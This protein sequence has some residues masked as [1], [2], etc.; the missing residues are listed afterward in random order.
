MRKLRRKK[1][2]GSDELPPNLLKDVVNEISKP[3][4]FII[5]KSLSSGLVPDL[6][7]ISKVTPL[8]K[9][10]SDF[11]NYRPISVLPCLSKVLEQVVHRQ[12]SNY[13]EKH[14][15]LKSSQFGFRPR[16][17][18]ELACNLLVDDIRKNI[19][20]G[21]LMGVKYLDLNKAFGTVSHSY[22]LSKLPS[23]GKNGNE[24]TW[25]EN[26]LFDRKQRIF[27]DGHLSKAYPVLRGVPQGSIF[28]QTLFLFHLDDIDNCLHHSSI[29]KYA[30]DTV[31]YVSGNDSESIQKKLNADILEVHNWLTDNDLSLNLKKG[32]T[33]TMIFVTSI[34]VEK[35]APLNIKIKGA[36]I[37]QTSSYKYLRTHL[38]STL[39]LNG[40][41][42]LKHKKLSS[43]LS[44]L[45]KLRPDLNVKASK[46]IYTNIVN[47]G[48]V[49]LNLSRT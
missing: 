19:N 48:T 8:Y 2:H 9:S 49:N 34:H 43:R 7:K 42:N 13:L 33:E 35:A 15:L 12:L 25:F 24:F 10:D 23:Y 41:F 45:S 36:S 39:A 47:C 40:N 29:I 14:Y 30:D 20:N 32:K 28:D 11:S 3:L 27:Y 26:C 37:N 38:D 18:T 21:L 4:A 1:A 22:L 31:I 17:S 44:L 6:W 5:N 46:M 16:G